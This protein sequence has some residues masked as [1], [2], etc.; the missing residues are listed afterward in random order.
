MVW[1]LIRPL[2]TVSPCRLQTYSSL[3][4]FPVLCLTHSHS[5][6][7]TIGVDH[8][9]LRINLT[10]W[11]YVALCATHCM[12]KKPNVLNLGT[13]LLLFYEGTHKNVNYKN[14]TFLTLSWFSKKRWQ[15]WGP[16]EELDIFVSG[17]GH[18]AFSVSY[19]SRC[20]D[21]LNVA[22]HY[23]QATLSTSFRALSLVLEPQL[24]MT[25]PHYPLSHS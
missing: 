14:Q 18:W 5:A 15:L 8:M 1:C 20:A 19:F 6:S 12:L 25:H 2:T 23:L 10:G 4:L 13:S 9:C 11:L 7:S 3:T 21:T 24:N 17:T 22:S 16:L